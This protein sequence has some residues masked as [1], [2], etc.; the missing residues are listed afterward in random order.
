MFVVGGFMLLSA[1]LMASAGRRQQ[2]EQAPGT[3]VPVGH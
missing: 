3:E 1:I 2:V